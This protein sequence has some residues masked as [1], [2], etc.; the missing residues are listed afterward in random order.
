MKKEIS[1]ILALDLLCSM[2]A[3]CGGQ[4]ASATAAAS[5]E[6]AFSADNDIIVYQKPDEGKLQL[7]VGLISTYYQGEIDML[8]E[9]E[10]ENPDI[11]LVYYD[12]TGGSDAYRPIDEMLDRGDAP[13]I[14]I[15]AYTIMDTS[16]LEDL[17]DYEGVKNFDTETLMQNAVDGHIYFLP[18]PMNFGC[19]HYN[20]ALFDQYGW[21]VPTTLDEFFALCEQIT[22]DTNGEVMPFNLNAKYEKEFSNVLFAM[23]Y[24]DIMGGSANQ[25]W[26]NDFKNGKATFAGHMEPVYD[27]GQKFIDAGILNQDSF[28]YSA[29][30]ISEEFKS[31]K[32]AMSTLVTS[33]TDA[34]QFPAFPFPGKTADRQIIM[35]SMNFMASVTKKDYTSEQSEVIRKFINYYCQP[36]TQQTFIGSAAMIASTKD[37]T[38]PDNAEVA[39][40]KETYEAGRSFARE[41][42]LLNNVSAGRFSGTSYIR[43]GLMDMAAGTRTEAEAIQ[44]VDT[45][46][47][48]A[49][50]NPE[51]D[52]SAETVGSASEDFTSLETSEMFADMFRQKTGSDL[53]LVLH[54]VTYRGNVMRIYSGSIT[55]DKVKYLKPRSFDNGATLVTAS[56]TG[57][58]IKN[59]LNDP[60]GQDGATADCV[61]AF[62]GLKAV[63]APW[64]P[65][66]SKVVSVTLADGTEIDDSRTYQVSFWLGTVNEKYYDPASIIPVEGTFDDI[67]TAYLAE[68]KSIAPAR[69]G[70]LTLQWS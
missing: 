65:V 23:T 61:Y 62:S 64:N 46:A 70:R 67:L 8:N 43:Q 51:L 39:S 18:G 52:L 10:K 29:T 32:L 12:I 57:R 40:L 13:D 35:R 41:L 66:G 1:S 22:K 27:L 48:D 30:K 34:S 56:M 47:A 7:T 42:F 6:S 49:M 31:G 24:D 50:A 21:T 4:T 17:S 53:S 33:G 5:A 20:K 45:A 15:N 25:K 58:Q 14:I 38:F 9:F 63:Y 28:T 60:Y 44:E 69:D 3:G 26:L 54:G 2:L 11:D 36:T 55:K 59:A 37:A 16:K 19:L 68:E